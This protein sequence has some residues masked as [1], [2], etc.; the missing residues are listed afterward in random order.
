MDLKEQRITCLRMAIDMGCKPDAVIATATELMTF[1]MGGAASPP[2]TVAEPQAPDADAI[3]ACG[4]ALPAS[5]TAD[6]VLAQPTGG[7]DTGVTEASPPAALPTEAEVAQEPASATESQAAS[8]APAVKPEAPA[9]AP[10]AV[11]PEAVATEP[12]SGPA[13]A[14]PVE[15]APEPAPV[16]TAP[17]EAA[18]PASEPVAATPAAPVAIDPAPMA[19]DGPSTLIPEAAAVAQAPAAE[20]GAAPAEDAPASVA[21]DLPTP[22]PTST[23]RNGAAKG[24]A[25]SAAATAS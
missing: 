16:A 12:V 15:A 13:E 9:E 17:V 6:L 7:S 11:E 1:V 24:D 8:P 19:A 20:Q 3:A 23:V 22:L 21:K 25:T 14:A 4:T 10:A 18:S 2:A 5:E